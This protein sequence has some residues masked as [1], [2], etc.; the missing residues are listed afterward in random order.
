MVEVRT[1]VHSEDGE[2]AAEGRCWNDRNKLCYK[3]S[4]VYGSIYAPM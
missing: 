3:M 2:E 4:E 1:M